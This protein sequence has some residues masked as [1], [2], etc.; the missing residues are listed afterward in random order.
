M[1]RRIWIAEGYA[2]DGE[3]YGRALQLPEPNPSHLPSPLK[4]I[5]TDVQRKRE[6][7]VKV[8]VGDVASCPCL[9]VGL[10]P[11][12]DEPDRGGNACAMD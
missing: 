8:N 6:A 7:I 9:D 4:N 11:I 3:M 12:E 5:G 2:T 10:R 1:S